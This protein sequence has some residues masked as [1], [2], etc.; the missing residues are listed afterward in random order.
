M[1]N[2]TFI[3]NSTTRDDRIL[4]FTRAVAWIIVPFLLAAFI[5]LYLDGRNTAAWFAWEIPSR[6]TTALMGAGYLGGAYFFLRVGLGRRRHQVHLGAGYLNA[7]SY[8]AESGAP[9]WHQVHLGFL[10]VTVYTITMLLATLLHRDKFITANWPFW[11]WLVLYVVSPLL[12]FIIW[13]INRRRDPR[14][15]GPG[16]RLIPIWLRRLMAVAGA[17]LLLLSAAAYVRPELFITIWPWTLTPLTARVMAGWHILLGAGALGL[18]TDKRWS[19]WPLP[20]QSITIWF[21][22][23]LLALIWHQRELG[24]AGLLNWYTLFVISGLAGL[25]FVTLIMRRQPASTT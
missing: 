7:N 17:F 12:V 3:K 9:L 11:V 23:F 22:L 14:L 18:A 13:W 19:A 1:A 8:T 5:I 20:M 2:Q 16:E 6:L 21:I 4:P 24:A 15:P 10:P 25:L